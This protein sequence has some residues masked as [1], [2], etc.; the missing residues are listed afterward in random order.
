MKKKY[1]FGQYAVTNWTRRRR[2]DVLCA[3]VKISHQ[4]I[5][6]QF[7]V[8]DFLAVTKG[9]VETNHFVAIVFGKPLTALR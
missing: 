4:L 9:V 8:V 6:V 2:L 7:T 1:L 3:I 5:E